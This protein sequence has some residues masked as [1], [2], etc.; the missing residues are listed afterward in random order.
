M[1]HTAV[2]VLQG[3]HP[4]QVVADFFE[5]FRVLRE[6]ARNVP[7]KRIKVLRE[8]LVGLEQGKNGNAGIHDVLAVVA[9]IVPAA[10]RIDD[11]AGALAASHLVGTVNDH[12]VVHVARGTRPLA[13]ILRF[14]RHARTLVVEP[15]EAR[16]RR[17]CR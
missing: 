5:Q 4:V 1:V 8:V 12:L 15:L 9:G 13:R 16:R 6:F 14:E 7:G 11:L 17:R 10:R 3:Q 2:L